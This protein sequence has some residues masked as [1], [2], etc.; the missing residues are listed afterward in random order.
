MRGRPKNLEDASQPSARAAPWKIGC[1]VVS[2]RHGKSDTTG[3]PRFSHEDFG[4]CICPDAD[5]RDELQWT[6]NLALAFHRFDCLPEPA[7][8]IINPR[9]LPFMDAWSFFQK[10]I[11]GPRRGSAKHMDLELRH[12][13]PHKRQAHHRITEVMEFDNEEAGFHR[14]NQRRFIK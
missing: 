6:Q 12:R 5:C 13:T 4:A 11:D 10:L 1:V 3:R 9:R 14:E 2:A 8:L 7:W